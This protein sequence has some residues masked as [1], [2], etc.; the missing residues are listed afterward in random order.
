MLA[1]GTAYAASQL[2]PRCLLLKPRT[3]RPPPFRA[4]LACSTAPLPAT[5]PTSVDGDTFTVV[6]PSGV[7]VDIQQH[8]RGG[9]Y[10]FGLDAL[11]LATDVSVQA[12]SPQ[13]GPCIVDLGA[14]CGVAGLC[15]AL[16]HGGSRLLAVEVQTTLAALSEHN[17]RAAQNVTDAPPGRWRVAQADVRDTAAWLTPEIAGRAD[18]VV[19][20][21][22]FFAAHAT[23]AAA[24]TERQ[25]G[26]QELHGSL[27]DF[28]AAAAACAHPA[29]GMAKFIVPPARLPEL[30]S[31]AAGLHAHSLRFIHPAPQADAYL[32]EVALRR[33]QC[34]G[35]GLLVR[36]ALCVRDEDGVYTHKVALRLATAAGAAASQDEVDRIRRTCVR[37]T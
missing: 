28:L 15:V 32:V 4:V 30:L 23:N 3:R 9:A 37:N 22:P 14:G 25:A 17:L 13:D 19:C 24:R 10:R 16:R 34:G 6:T 1:R 18:L 29:S 33:Q 27:A 31:N 12:H 36:P 11:L 21:P 8:K 35:G 7:S 26:R 5:A 20:N 2:C